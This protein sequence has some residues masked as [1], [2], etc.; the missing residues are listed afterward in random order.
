M[1]FTSQEI[2]QRSIDG[3]GR[4]IFKSVSNNTRHTVI[5]S[6]T[7][8]WASGNS[9]GTT[10]TLNIVT[11]PTEV[12]ANNEYVAFITNTPSLE[13]PISVEFQNK[14][15][16]DGTAYY[17]TV[18]TESCAAGNAITKLVKPF[19]IGSEGGRIIAS[20][21]SGVT[22]GIVSYVHILST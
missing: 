18:Q 4:I 22:S 5:C 12:Q 1:G 3:D 2:L 15:T 6:G 8:T 19:L 9:A 11:P 21:V 10:Q 17:P 14:Y 16:I 20:N 13:T 7:F